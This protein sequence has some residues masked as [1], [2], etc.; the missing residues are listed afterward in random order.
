VECF[1]LQIGKR[2]D[3]NAP[4]AATFNEAQ[5]YPGPVYDFQWLLDS[6]DQFR[7]QERAKLL[8]KDNYVMTQ[9]EYNPPAH[10]KH[11]EDFSNPNSAVANPHSKKHPHHHGHGSHSGQRTRFTVRELIKIFEVTS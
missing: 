3:P 10:D 2:D 5:F 7:T 1:T 6:A 11:G 4:H 8:N 9:I